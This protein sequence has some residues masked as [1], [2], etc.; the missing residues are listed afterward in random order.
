MLAVQWR[1]IRKV[2][3]GGRVEG[4][5]ISARKTEEGRWV[6]T[7][8][9]TLPKRFAMDE[10]R[11]LDVAEMMEVVKK[12]VPRVPEGRENLVLKK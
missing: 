6:K 5:D 8:V 2:T 7:I 12:M 10:A 1:R 3:A 4:K 11:R 9:L